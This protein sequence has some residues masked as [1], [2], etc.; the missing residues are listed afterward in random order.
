MIQLQH[1][2]Y[3]FIQGPARLKEVSFEILSAC[4]G[5]FIL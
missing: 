5:F 4:Q 2:S 3:L 1:G